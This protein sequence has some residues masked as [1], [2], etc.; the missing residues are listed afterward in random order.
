MDLFATF[1]NKKTQLF[2]LW[3]I[4]QQAFAT[5][6]MS[7]SWQNMFANA[8]PPIQMIPRVLQHMKKFHCKIILI[9]PHWPR[10]YWFPQ[11]LKMLLAYP[12]KLT[13]WK[14]LLS[15]VKG[16]ILHPDPQSL[17]LTAWLLLTDTSLQRD[18][19]KKTRKLL[20]SSWRKGTK[21]DY[22]SKFKQFSCWCAEQNVEPFHASLNECADMVKVGERG[23]TFIRTVLSKQ[24]RPNHDSSHI[25]IPCYQDN[26]YLDPRRCVLHYIKKTKK[27]RQ[28]AV[29]LFLATR[30]PHQPVTAQTI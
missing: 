16:Q 27:Y 28:G 12:V 23:I 14:N 13:S 29:K 24:D 4:H 8:F 20:A 10:Q 9:A 21:K 6:A 2:C 25:F 1:Q 22:N 7:V 30:K 3:M 11:L 18:F 17:K 15:Q 26:K 19:Q 5:D